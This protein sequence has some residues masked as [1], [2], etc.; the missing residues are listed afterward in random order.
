MQRSLPGKNILLF[1]N[2]E[3]A[4]VLP[5]QP[6][7]KGRSA[8]LVS[9]RNEKIADRLYFYRVFGKLE[10]DTVLRIL[11]A[12]I[13]LAA[14]TIAEIVIEQN[15]YIKRLKSTGVT[16]K[17]LKDKWPYMNWNDPHAIWLIG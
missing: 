10:H 5:Q 6:V 2:E 8:E 16:I 17:A 3:P 7:R 4:Q 13:D 11:S 15:D 1:L 12:E 9:R 14:F